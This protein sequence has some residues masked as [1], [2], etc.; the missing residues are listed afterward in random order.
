MYI[1]PYSYRWRTTF[2]CLVCQFGRQNCSW[3]FIKAQ[4][5]HCLPIWLLP[6]ENFTSISKTFRLGVNEEGRSDHNPS[7]DESASFSFAPM[8]K[9][10]LLRIFDSRLAQSRRHTC[11]L[12]EGASRQR[13]T[14]HPR[15]DVNATFDNA[16]V[17]RELPCKQALSHKAG[18]IPEALMSI[19]RKDTEED[20]QLQA[21][22]RRESR[23]FETPAS[24]EDF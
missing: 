18:V 21:K 23:L 16:F 17:E 20:A 10:D 6:E 8:P 1:I 11:P 13:S 3:F 14:V 15:K 2:K 12:Q 5:Q 7:K 4:V 24:K 22:E 19:S 9:E